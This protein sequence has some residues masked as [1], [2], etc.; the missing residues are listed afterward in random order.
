MGSSSECM[1][2][3]SERVLQRFHASDAA[4]L[5][6]MTNRMMRI[7][8]SGLDARGIAC[9]QWMIIQHA[10]C[11]QTINADGKQGGS[12]RNYK[13][14][15][16]LSAGCTTMRALFG[17]LGVLPMLAALFALF[18]GANKTPQLEDSFC[19]DS[20]KKELCGPHYL[21]TYLVQKSDRR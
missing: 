4:G 5:H 2:R 16:S 19:L 7:T 6:G 20:N 12:T 21:S 11:L 15:P 18:A 1:R 8:K 10:G 17:R 13:C 14:S 3:V 9:N